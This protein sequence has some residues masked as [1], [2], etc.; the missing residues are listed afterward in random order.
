MKKRNLVLLGAAFAVFMLFAGCQNNAGDSSGG[1]NE[2][3]DKAALELIKGK[4]KIPS[5]VKKASDLQLPKEMGGAVIIWKS[6]KPDVIGNDGTVN[7]PEGAGST[8]VKLTATISK[9]GSSVDVP[10]TVKVFHKNQPIDDASLVQ[11][12]KEKLELPKTELITNEKLE[13]PQT[14]GEGADVVNVTW[15]SS[16]KTVIADNGTVTR[17]DGAGTTEVKLTATLKK[18]N[19]T[20]EKE[21]TLTVYNK[22]ETITDKQAVVFAKEN[23]SL[24]EIVLEGSTINLKTSAENGVSITWS[25]SDAIIN[26]ADGKVN[27]L[28]DTKPKSV[29]LTAT[30]SKGTESATKKFMI[31]VRPT[32]AKLVDAAEASLTYPEKIETDSINLPKAVGEGDYA[33]TVTWTISDK[34]VIS[35][36]GTVTRPLGAGEKPVTLKAEL[37]KGSILKVKTFNLKVIYGKGNYWNAYKDE[38]KSGDV[39]IKES[40]EDV[41]AVVS[42]D[43]TG[44][45]DAGVFK[46][47][48]FPTAATYMVSFEIKSSEAAETTFSVHHIGKGNLAEAPVK[49]GTNWA[50]QRYLVAVDD[51]SNGENLD[52]SIALK[53]GTTNIRNVKVFNTWDNWQEWEKT[54]YGSWGLWKSDKVG[55]LASSTAYDFAKDSI[56]VKNYLYTTLTHEGDWAYGFTYSRKYTAGAHYFKFKSTGFN[57]KIA[58]VAEGDKNLS[59]SIVPASIIDGTECWFSFDIPSEYVGKKIAMNFLTA[60]KSGPREETIK[61]ED[62]KIFDA[63]PSS[64]TEL[65]SFKTFI[66]LNDSWSIENLTDNG[67]IISGTPVASPDSVSLKLANDVQ[68]GQYFKLIYGPK[69]FEAGMYKITYNKNVPENGMGWKELKIGKTAYTLGGDY[70]LIPEA[71]KGKIEFGL[72]KAGDYSISNMKIEKLDKGLLELGGIVGDVQEPAWEIDNVNWTNMDIPGGIYEYEFTAKNTL[73]K[74]QVSAFKGQWKPH[75]LG[76]S[77]PADGNEVKLTYDDG[78]SCVS[79]NLTPG[80]KYKITVRVQGFD[81]YAK[82]TPVTATV[83]A[84]WSIENSTSVSDIITYSNATDDSMTFTIKNDI[85]DGALVL[86]YGKENFEYGKAYRPVY[87]FSDDRVLSFRD[88][89]TDGNASY[90]RNA[91]YSWFDKSCNGYYCFG[92]KKGGTYTISNMK[93]EGISISNDSLLKGGIAGFG[94]EWYW[95]AENASWH[96]VD[97]ANKVYEYFFR[98]GA[99]SEEWKVLKFRDWSVKFGNAVV[100]PDNTEVLLQENPAGDKNCKAENLTVGKDYTLT[101]TVRDGKVYAKIKQR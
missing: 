22:G 36:N 76:A 79:K 23:L 88:W 58:V 52:I 96:K 16:N 37:K 4:L 73:H 98:A 80:N 83:S 25:S 24:P 63:K 29:T 39:R 3:S 42:V 6:D 18:G 46:K 94:G 26:A 5:V 82:I 74:W 99:T 32:D 17:P 93:I 89:F 86:R 41:E 64:G 27:N 30:I 8:D 92:L 55:K 68:D 31:A 14:V 1:G 33:V 53:K 10:F 85:S 69:D 66:T 49:I 61:I 95:K 57:G 56:K 11:Q 50:E 45:W 75:F 7:I 20:A 101:V 67:S 44:T 72:K 2:R 77:V 84:K 21:F 62:V 78:N 70:V 38:Y 43:T 87:N 81:V 91:D 15:S 65:E 35:E 12:A 100:P 51:E 47:Y 13:L 71:G 34:D 19:I 54:E 9:G 28:T 97:E 60:D 48:V 59:R 90:K 40:G